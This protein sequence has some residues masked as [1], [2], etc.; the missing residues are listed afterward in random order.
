[1]SYLRITIPAKYGQ[2]SSLR[3][4]ILCTLLNKYWLTEKVVTSHYSRC[5][6]MTW[7]LLDVP[8]MPYSPHPFQLLFNPLVFLK[9]LIFLLPDIATTTTYFCFFSTT[10][11]S[12]QLATT[13]LSVWIWKFHR[14]LT[15]LSTLV[16]HTCLYVAGS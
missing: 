2:Q 12:G 9:I 5:L 10:V 1:M 4:T 14:I 15:H 7:Q 8:L 16:H 3:P 13:I 11:T 6:L